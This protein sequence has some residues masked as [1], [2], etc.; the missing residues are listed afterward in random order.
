MPV[1]NDALP[2]LQNVLLYYFFSSLYTQF[3]SELTSETLELECG[4]SLLCLEAEGFSK[5]LCSVLVDRADVMRG[6]AFN[7]TLGASGGEYHEC[8]K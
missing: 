8:S 7:P 1:A 3:M 4:S 5:V 2:L 6:A